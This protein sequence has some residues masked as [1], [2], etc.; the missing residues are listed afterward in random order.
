[1]LHSRRTMAMAKV[2]S[3]SD[4][5]GSAARYATDRT[6]RCRP[7]TGCASAEPSALSRFV[8][9]SVYSVADAVDLPR[10]AVTHGCSNGR[11][12][13]ANTHTHTHTHTTAGYTDAVQKYRHTRQQARRNRSPTTTT[14]EHAATRDE[15]APS[16][17][18]RGAS[19][20]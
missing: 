6:C 4:S 20:P 15:L 1:M 19:S 17:R 7:D 9:V 5:D 18:T 16:Q 10:H 14:T 12:D 8:S 11:S 3:F 2:R 13:G